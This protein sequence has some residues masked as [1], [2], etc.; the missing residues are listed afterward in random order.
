MYK[1]DVFVKLKLF[2]GLW[3]LERERGIGGQA[4]DDRGVLLVK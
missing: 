4:L 1:Q 3:T 2:Q